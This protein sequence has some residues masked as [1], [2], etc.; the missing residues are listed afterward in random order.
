MKK[1]KLKQSIDEK[2]KFRKSEVISE[3]AAALEKK[4]SKD[5]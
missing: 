4:I 3:K 1:K 2:N 5:K